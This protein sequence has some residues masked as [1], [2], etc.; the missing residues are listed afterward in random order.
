[1]LGIGSGFVRLLHAQSVRGLLL[2]QIN[3]IMM[4]YITYIPQTFTNRKLTMIG[5]VQLILENIMP[6]CVTGKSQ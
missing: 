5:Y 2:C 1:M 3:T 6:D 4:L